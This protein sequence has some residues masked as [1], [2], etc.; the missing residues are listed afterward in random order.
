MFW[1]IIKLGKWKMTGK[2]FPVSEV[3]RMLSIWES[4]GWYSAPGVTDLK[5]ANHVSRTVSTFWPWWMQSRPERR[6]CWR[7]GD[8]VSKHR[9]RAW[10]W[11]DRSG[12]SRRMSRRRSNGALVSGWGAHGRARQEGWARKLGRHQMI[13]WKT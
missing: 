9:S 10:R 5:W 2:I 8:L 3:S 4:S 7:L 1:P 13:F 11:M 6:V 12:R